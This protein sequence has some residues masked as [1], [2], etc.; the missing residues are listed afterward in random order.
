[1]LRNQV[2]DFYLFIF[3]ATGWDCEEGTYQNAW[4]LS[5]QQLPFLHIW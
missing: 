3:G 5:K 2:P 1:M 4:F